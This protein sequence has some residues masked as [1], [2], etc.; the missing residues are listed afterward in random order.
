MSAGAGR[1]CG[2]SLITM[3]QFVDECQL[4][5]KA[6]D[7]GAGCVSFRRE[8][9][10]VLGGPNGG[11]GGNGGSRRKLF[12]S[13][14]PSADVG[15]AANGGARRVPGARLRTM[16][17]K[18]LSRANTEYAATFG[19]LSLARLLEHDTTEAIV[20]TLVAIQFYLA[21]TYNKKR[22][23]SLGEIAFKKAEYEAQLIELRQALSDLGARSSRRHSFAP[24]T[25]SRS[26]AILPLRPVVRRRPAPSQKPR[27]SAALTTASR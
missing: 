16:V 11:D 18:V 24:G 21:Q 6:G 20:T 5:V 15:G 2:V 27:W 10:V 4:N 8:G 9:P 7:G 23:T 19:T 1:Q 3:S 22:S 25:R 14:A 26:K 13:T 12:S 17:K